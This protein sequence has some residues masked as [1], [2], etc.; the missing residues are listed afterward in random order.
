[1]EKCTLCEQNV[2]QGELPQCVSQ[3]GGRARF[4][5]DFEQGSSRS[6]RPASTATVRTWH[7][8]GNA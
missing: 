4:F 3:C 8:R 7:V 1:M 2:G 6:R 5:G